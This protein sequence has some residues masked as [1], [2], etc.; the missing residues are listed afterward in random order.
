MVDPYIQGN[1]TLKNKLGITEYS[2]LNNAEKDITFTKFLNI[3]QTYKTKFDVEYLKSI[4]KHIFEDVFDWAGQF[5]TVPIYKQEIVV[6]GLSLEYAPVK[7]IE[8]RLKD[9]LNRMNNTEWNKMNSLDEISMQ[10]T[11]YLAEIWAVHPF[12][13]GNTRTTLTF[14]NQFAKEHGF[15]LNLGGLLDNLTRKYDSKGEVVQYS[16]RDKFVLAAIPEE[17]A[18]EPEHLNLLIHSAMVKGIE[19]SIENLQKNLQSSSL[20]NNKDDEIEI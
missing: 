4:H 1:G 10:F 5:R 13:D 15:P 2:E 12:R 14:A 7:E 19:Q 3:E 9:I 18:P 20:Q 16:I 11:K 8:P 17:Y 6:P